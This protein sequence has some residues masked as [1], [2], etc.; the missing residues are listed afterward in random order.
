MKKIYINQFLLAGT[1]T[2]MSAFGF[3]RPGTGVYDR[4]A[5]TAAYQFH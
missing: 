1:L 3:L 4:Y 2:G 5:R